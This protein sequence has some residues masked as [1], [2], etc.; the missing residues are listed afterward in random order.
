VAVGRDG[1]LTLHLASEGPSP[2]AIDEPDA[3]A[4]LHASD[5]ID[6]GIVALS[7][8][9][10]VESLPPDDADELIG[11]YS[12]T[13]L[14]LPKSFGAW[15]TIPLADPDPRRV[16]ALIDEGFAGLCVPTTALADPAAVDRLGPVLE[17]LERRGAPLFVHP[18]PPAQAAAGAPAWWPAATDYVAGLHA[19]WCAW[20]A[21]GRYNH[22]TLKVLFAALAGLAPLHAERLASRGAPPAS[23]DPYVFYDTSS[24]GPAA[25]AAMRAAVGDGQLVYGSDRPVVVPTPT[26]DDNLLTTNPGRLLR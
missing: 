14:A 8:A 24:Y 11:A 12:Q 21:R 20:L 17:A 5:G 9:L 22:P 16:G 13:A 19:A 1:T 26:T 23:H 18:G 7:A 4:A 3:R 2:L 10:G 25:I 6:R 15:G